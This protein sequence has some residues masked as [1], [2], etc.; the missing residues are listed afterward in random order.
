M[1]SLF[2]IGFISIIISDFMTGAYVS[3]DRQR[4]NIQRIKRGQKY[5][6]K[7]NMSV[8]INLL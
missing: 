4:L 5:G 2:I 3:G 1:Y 6:K 7:I 8:W